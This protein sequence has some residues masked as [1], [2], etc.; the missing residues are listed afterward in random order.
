MRPPSA[1]RGGSSREADH[2]PGA[3]SPN[4]AVSLQLCCLR[5]VGSTHNSQAPNCMKGRPLVNGCSA[6]QVTA[7][8]WHMPLCCPHAANQRCR[9]IQPSSFGNLGTFPP[10][11]PCPGAREAAEPSGFLLV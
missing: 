10:G 3:S 5:Q 6:W 1:T 8:G 4:P 11:A 7:L 9:E 2:H